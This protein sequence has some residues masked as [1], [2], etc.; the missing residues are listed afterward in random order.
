[1]I[2]GGA[3]RL[4]AVLLFLVH[5]NKTDFFKRSK[6]GASCSYNDFC[7]TFFYTL[8]FIKPFTEWKCAVKYGNLLA[9][10]LW[11][12][13]NKLRCKRNFRH[14]NDDSLVIIYYTLNQ[15]HKNACFSR[16]CNTEQKA[17]MRFWIGIFG[18]EV[19]AGCLL[20]FWQCNRGKTFVLC[21][22]LNTEH[23]FVI[24]VDKTFFIKC[25]RNSC[26]DTREVTNLFNG[27]SACHFDKV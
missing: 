18:I 1:M 22:V 24:V 7:K 17:C 21:S 5:Y 11:K 9:E 8:V 10:T 19:I 16:T 20:L 12:G 3:F 14:H 26:C 4:I 23:F 27:S 13:W 2:S 6:H 25:V 15:F